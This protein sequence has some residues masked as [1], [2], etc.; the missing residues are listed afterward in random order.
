MVA[1][2]HEADYSG[3][4]TKDLGRGPGHVGSWDRPPETKP[5]GMRVAN[6]T[7]FEGASAEMIVPSVCWFIHA[8]PRTA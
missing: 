4:T 3:S 8:L 7:S 6:S 5:V 1:I 2:P